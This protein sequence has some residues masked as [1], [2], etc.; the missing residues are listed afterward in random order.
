MRLDPL[1]YGIAAVYAAVT[2]Y[3][4]PLPPFGRSERRGRDL[5][6]YQFELEK[7]V[8]GVRAAGIHVEPDA[9]R[10]APAP[11]PTAAP[12][13]GT[14]RAHRRSVLWLPATS[15]TR[16][17]SGAGAARPPP[18]PLR[19]CAASATPLEAD[20]AV[21]VV[22][23]PGDI[24]I[25]ALDVA[26]THRANG[27]QVAKGVRF[28]ETQ[29]ARLCGAKVN[30]T[31]RHLSWFELDESTRAVLRQ[32][33]LVHGA[34]SLRSP[35]FETDR[36][37]VVAIIAT[38]LTVSA[39]TADDLC[40]LYWVHGVQTRVAPFLGQ[41]ELQTPLDFLRAVYALTN[42]PM[43]LAV[44]AQLGLRADIDIERLEAARL[45][46]EQA[47]D[48]DLM[49]IAQAKARGRFRL[50]LENDLAES[51]RARDV[52]PDTAP[53]YKE[54]GVWHDGFALRG[55]VGMDADAISR[56]LQQGGMP[57]DEADRLT[58]RR[59]RDLGE[60]AHYL[61]GTPHHSMAS[62]LLRLGPAAGL[63]TKGLDNTACLLAAFQALVDLLTASGIYP[64]D[65]LLAAARHCTRACGVLDSSMLTKE[66]LVTREVRTL[67]Q[68]GSPGWRRNPTGA[69]P[70][71]SFKWAHL[72]AMARSDRPLTDSP[73]EKVA[74]DLYHSVM[75]TREILV[76]T[77][78]E[79]LNEAE[80][81]WFRS[82]LRAYLPM[83]VFDASQVARDVLRA[84][85]GMSKAEIKTVRR[86]RYAT[87]STKFGVSR[88]T[89]ATRSGT[90]VQEFLVRSRLDSPGDRIL[91]V[92]SKTVDTKFELD[93]ALLRFNEGL[94]DTPVV[95]A[96]AE[97][98]LRMTRQWTT[99]VAIDKT[100]AEIV[101]AWRKQS[102]PPARTGHETL[103]AL[104]RE[105]RL[106][107][108]Q[109]SFASLNDI[110]EALT[111]GDPERVVDLVP[112]L[113]A[114]YQIGQGVW[115][116][117]WRQAGVGGV[118]L[119]ADILFTWIF[120]LAGR[121]EAE[122]VASALDDSSRPPFEPLAV[123]LLK[124]YQRDANGASYSI[125]P[126]G[127]GDYASVGEAASHDLSYSEEGA[128]ADNEGRLLPKMP[129][130]FGDRL[131]SA[132]SA[133]LRRTV[134]DCKALLERLDH[135]DG[136]HGE[137]GCSLG[138]C[139]R[140]AGGATAASDP[141]IAG[142][143]VE[144]GRLAEL[145]A[146][147]SRTHLWRSLVAYA[148]YTDND[149]PFSIVSGD[150]RPPVTLLA[151]REIHMPVDEAI[152][153]RQYIGWLGPVH[154]KVLEVY[155]HEAFHAL[156]FTRD[157]AGPFPWLH[158]GVV[159]P[160]CDQMHYESVT[161]ESD[162]LFNPR[163][164]YQRYIPPEESPM[165][166]EQASFAHP[167]ARAATLAENVELDA[168]FAR[169]NARLPDYTILGIRAENRVTIKRAPTLVTQVT[170]VVS[171]RPRA[172][173]APLQFAQFLEASEVVSLNPFALRTE[174]VLLFERLCAGND[175]FL[176]TAERWLMDMEG[177]GAW[178]FVFDEHVW[179][180][181][182]TQAWRVDRQ[183][184]TVYF[185]PHDLFYLSR[186]GPKKLDFK[187]TFIGFIGNEVYGAR[188]LPIFDPRFNRGPGVLWENLACDETGKI[189]Q[190]VS[191]EL[192]ED[193]DTLWDRVVFA[194]KAASDEDL[195]LGPVLQPI[196]KENLAKMRA[197]ESYA[198]S[199]IPLAGR[200]LS[201]GSI[202]T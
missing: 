14:R 166:H 45:L 38:G 151:R 163:I 84:A 189:G 106:P 41:S 4:R 161:T 184:R 174:W 75:N 190:R 159:L 79:A 56:V 180:G 175:L 186:D 1:M 73:F 173:M 162:A 36:K 107:D 201:R 143:A 68:A 77:S 185:N 187:R 10:V 53:S 154:F 103:V 57:R 133:D 82:R 5:A 181:R 58:L 146:A 138:R 172:Y 155:L 136:E 164:V 39:Y 66:E 178:K 100:A 61:I 144:Q 89:P 17:A 177:E 71:L 29:L 96:K 183:A 153:A 32:L 50:A 33:G 120:N 44:D 195:R 135:M 165:R 69:N 92:G 200:G 72:R 97:E 88:R 51:L 65:P 74:V 197:L 76:E 145:R 167:E 170:E 62:I 47:L 139:W 118:R 168:L 18:P 20:P 23:D 128:G 102:K 130:Q 11:A 85:F 132:G 112:F 49:P 99:A 140:P 6:R 122:T 176:S 94:A 131:L 142:S 48:L 30:A 37:M 46:Y 42:L 148:H 196:G 26:Q 24:L 149:A 60:D 67:L 108:L 126:R 125:E 95:R 156:T 127:T 192:A 7:V 91:T 3:A 121:E 111:S 22:Q 150:T 64:I 123:R 116:E 199:E 129:E 19:A 87:M 158:R 8:S 198:D 134:E 93:G 54:T 34:W 152:T 194:S 147:F 52:I 78:M 28:A 160:S 2:S 188:N 31:Q 16:S 124:D 80:L 137:A 119:G 104:L 114:A 21:S 115:H 157:N 202:G 86:Y 35:D 191:A 179:G 9:L 43:A 117:N 113:G 12:A 110:Y 109:P 63:S 70:A 13:G 27:S 25:K 141:F 169:R 59:M 98:T 101:N 15:Q 83:P 55:A 105:V 193:P 40:R 182:R 81:A 90:W 171:S